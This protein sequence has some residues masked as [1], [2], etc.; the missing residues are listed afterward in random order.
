VECTELTN[1]ARVV[2]SDGDLTVE[3]LDARRQF[4]ETVREMG[5]LA[6][7]ERC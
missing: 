6:L 2:S 7:L 4:A 3:R 5:E 1:L